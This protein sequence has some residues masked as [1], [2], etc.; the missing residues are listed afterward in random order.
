ML[1]LNTHLGPAIAIGDMHMLARSTHCTRI[2]SKRDVQTAITSVQTIGRCVMG[3]C[4]L[5]III[6]SRQV[7]TS[8][9]EPSL[10]PSHWANFTLQDCKNK[11]L[12]TN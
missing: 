9:R 8:P 7:H 3:H 4:S 5:S 12:V 1:E 10:C 2:G 11:S 6:P